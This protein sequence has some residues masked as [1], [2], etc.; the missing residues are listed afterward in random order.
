MV[1][2]FCRP[3]AFSRADTFSM[4]SR[5]RSSCTTSWLP[6]GTVARPCDQELADPV[7]AAHVVVLALVDL[8]LDLRLAVVRRCRT[9]RCARPAAACC[10]G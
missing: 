4:P 2:C 10:G 8:D 5:F 3:V 6:A 7:V 1:T 9:P